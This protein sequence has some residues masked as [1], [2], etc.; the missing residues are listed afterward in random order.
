MCVG[1]PQVCIVHKVG[2][3]NQIM[4]SNFTTKLRLHHAEKER[5]RG[6]YLWLYG[7]TLI[8]ITDI[9]V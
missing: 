6:A 2:E 7:K 4:A 3:A 1:S 5:E 9:T 8:C